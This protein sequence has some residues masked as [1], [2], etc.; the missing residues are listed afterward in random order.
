MMPRSISEPWTHDKGLAAQ[1]HGRLRLLRNLCWAFLL[2]RLDHVANHGV[3]GSRLSLELEESQLGQGG[4]AWSRNS[5]ELHR[6]TSAPRYWRWPGVWRRHR[7][8]AAPA[9]RLASSDRSNRSRAD[10]ACYGAHA[11][12]SA[13]GRRGNG[14]NQIAWLASTTLQICQNLGCVCAP[15]PPP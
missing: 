5:E 9:R 4:P 15:R 11:C 3:N 10:G 6:M 7:N 13:M 12:G 14:G 2:G 8:Y 1:L